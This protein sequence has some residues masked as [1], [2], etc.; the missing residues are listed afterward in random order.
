M[1]S[2]YLVALSE[3]YGI[4]LS[5]ILVAGEEAGGNNIATD[6]QKISS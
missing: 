1:F 5:S 3:N 6:R 4:I 2:K